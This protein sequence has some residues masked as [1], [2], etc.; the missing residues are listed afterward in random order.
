MIPAHDGGTV[1]VGAASWAWLPWDTRRKLVRVPSGA[2]HG[3]PHTTEEWNTDRQE[4]QS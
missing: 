3:H 4:Q 1:S 2:H